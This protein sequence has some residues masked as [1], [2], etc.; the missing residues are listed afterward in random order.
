MDKCLLTNQCSYFAGHWLNGQI[1]Y[2]KDYVQVREM[3]WIVVNSHLDMDGV[4]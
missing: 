3:F 4:A 1:E 2:A